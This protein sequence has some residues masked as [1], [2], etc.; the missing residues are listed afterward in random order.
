MV[1]TTLMVILICVMLEIFLRTKFIIVFTNWQQ[2]QPRQKREYL[3]DFII[4]ILHVFLY[5]CLLT[6]AH[7][8][9]KDYFIIKVFFKQIFFLS[10]CYIRQEVSNDAFHIS[11]IKNFDNRNVLLREKNKKTL[12]K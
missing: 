3:D 11:C 7:S 5:I 6:G 4:I 8:N 9:K 10:F 2:Q 12:I 1:A